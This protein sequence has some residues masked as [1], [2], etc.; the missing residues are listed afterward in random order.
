MSY[1]ISWPAVAPPEPTPEIPVLL[2]LPQAG[3][4]AGRFRAWQERLAPHATVLGVQLPGR[5]E[6]WT[7]P[8]PHDLAEVVESVVSELSRLVDRGRPTVIFGDSFGG[9]IGY[10]IAGVLRPQALIVCVCRA[11]EYWSRTGGISE[12][13]VAYLVDLAPS[14]SPL[15]DAL[16]EEVRQLAAES[17]MR[18]VLLSATY[19]HRAEP[20]VSCPV[21]AWGALA[22]DTVSAQQLDDWRTAT[23]GTLHRHDFQGGHR[24]SVDEL[25]AVLARVADVLGVPV[26]QPSGVLA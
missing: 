4:G 14:Y 18:D 10:L 5:E 13:D 11:P 2:C 16:A 3:A 17:L 12:T 24:V 9:L 8:A 15:P 25:D 7:D 26:A 19:R 1:L 23:T 22:D 6:R 21:H 20:G